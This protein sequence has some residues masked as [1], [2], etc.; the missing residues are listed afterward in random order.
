MKRFF[1]ILS[2]FLLAHLFCSD[3]RA[4]KLNVS[5]YNSWSAGIKF[6]LLPFYGD[7]R[8]LH[9][10]TE[11]NYKKTNTGF[12]VEVTKNFNHLLG[13]KADLLFGSFSGSSP[14]L[15]MHFLGNFKEYTLSGLININNLISMYPRREKFVNAYLYFGAG[16]VDFRSRVYS[17]DENVYVKGYGWDSLGLTKTKGTTELVFPIG[18]G[19]KLK[20]DSK[21]DVGFEI[22]LHLTKTDKLDAWVVDGS[23]ND[24]YGYAAISITYKI[25]SKKEYV[26]WVNP[27]EDTTLASALLVQN[28]FQTNNNNTNQNNPTVNNQNNNNTNNTNNNTTVTVVELKYFIVSSTFSSK[29][30]AKES[31]ERLIQKGYNDA[32]FFFQKSSGNYRVYYKG[33]P[34]IADALKDWPELKKTNTYAKLFEKKSKESFSDITTAYKSYTT[35]T[36]KDTTKVKTNTNVTNTN[37]S[38]NN[39]TNNNT[40]I[41]TTNNTTTNTTTTT[42]DMKFF[43]IA[44]SY[45]TQQLADEAV[46]AIKLKGFADALIVDQN[47]YGSYRVAYKG[48]ATRDEAS[49][50]LTGIKQNT[51]T[52]AWI[53][54]KK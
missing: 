47:T 22:G 38:T 11:N 12:A 16:M 29:K 44:G 24:R 7:V 33:Y 21:I 3:A 48:Y 46:A 51:N 50:D 14:N 18:I 27:Y 32:N 26:D 23:Y 20:A 43:I 52:S 1:I 28:N 54:E 4:Q 40:N 17:F 34:E 10:S 53:Y 8:Q 25:G 42:V 41:T 2:V 5:D 30:L 13:L 6:G 39:T 45:T 49:V 37:Q 36:P 19:V 35:P 15:N 9:Y 31:A